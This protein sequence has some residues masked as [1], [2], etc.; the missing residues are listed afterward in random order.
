MVRMAQHEWQQQGVSN[1]RRRSLE[2]VMKEQQARTKV[3][4][5]HL[6]PSL[7]WAVFQD[8]IAV[9][10]AGTYTWWSYHPGKSSHKRQVYSRAYIN[11]KKPEDVID[12]Y[13][14]FNGHV[15]VNERGAQ[16]KAL[17]EYA[18]YQRVP[19]PRSKKDV[20]EGTISTD[21]EYLAFVEQLAKPAE[22]L[23]SAEVQLERKEAEKAS[24]LASG[25]SKDAVVVTPLM[26]YVRSRRAA[27]STPQRGMSSSAKLAARSGGVPVS[28]FKLATQKR[29]SEKGRSGSSSYTGDSA[30]TTK[31]SANHNSASRDEL[32]RKERE[33]LI[34][35]KRKETG[36][37]KEKKSVREAVAAAVRANS[38]SQRGEFSKE[39]TILLTKDM[40]EAPSEG[41][42]L[43]NISAGGESGSRTSVAGKVSAVNGSGEGLTAGDVREPHKREYKRKQML[44]AKDKDK[45]LA[46]DPEQAVSVANSV[47]V[48]T[49]NNQRHRSSGPAKV[50]AGGVQQMQSAVAHRATSLG[51]S[52]SSGK[53]IH[54]QEYGGR[55]SLRGTPAQGSSAPGLGSDSHAQPQASGTQVEKVGKRPPRPQAIRLAGKDQAISLVSSVEAEG[56]AGNGEER[57]VKQVANDGA[58]SSPSLLD[59]QDARRLR[60][61]DRPDRPVW[62]PRRREGVTGKADGTA[63]ANSPASAAGTASTEGTSSTASSGTDV[64]SKND[65]AERSSGR[66]NGR[67]GSEVRSSE[68]PQTSGGGGNGTFSKLRYVETGGRI[69]RGGRT[70]AAVGS[71]AAHDGSRTDAKSVGASDD[72]TSQYGKQG[73]DNGEPFV[74][75][76]EGQQSL[77]TEDRRRQGGSFWSESG[78][79]HRQGGRRER[80]GQQGAKEGDGGVVGTEAASKLVKRGRGSPASGSNEKQVWVAVQKTVSG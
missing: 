52:I 53:Q 77:V 79:S 37:G 54:R 68:P 27:K 10:Y 48:G 75:S 18:P 26:E 32:Q 44:V 19:K 66:H 69:P 23:P 72:V 2:T 24:N 41:R 29:G 45:E 4:V 58:A 78:G 35:R 1:A 76:Q 43:Q 30:S 80:T 25:T 61:K 50:A 17:V 13:E 22:Y 33:H 60:N 36:E 8:Q 57:S 62:T 7:A 39:K 40:S 16:Y 28:A 34:E 47:G 12:F 9:K 6:P 59:K 49:T 70:V 31:E 74:Q 46:V 15:F 51:D 42:A 67:S 73:R 71:Q 63:F 3:S 20:R 55:T 5:R 56:Q 11:F 65:R 14:D 38:S 64:G 21:P